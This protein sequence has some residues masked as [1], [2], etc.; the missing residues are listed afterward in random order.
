[1]QTLM[2]WIAIATTVLLAPLIIFIVIVVL[3]QPAKERE[4]AKYAVLWENE[5]DYWSY[6]DDDDPEDQE[7]CQQTVPQK[8]SDET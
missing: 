6:D 3:R 2:T 8:G 7:T 5:K 1:M 4:G